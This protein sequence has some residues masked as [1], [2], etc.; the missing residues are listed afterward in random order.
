MSGSSLQLAL[1]ALSLHLT[2][3]P[4]ILVLPQVLIG[5]QDPRQL[6]ELE[7]R[8]AQKRASTLA[9]PPLAVSAR[10]LQCPYLQC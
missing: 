9:H 6:E 8:L 2:I 1:V 3:Q 10:T 5:L 7:A 4:S